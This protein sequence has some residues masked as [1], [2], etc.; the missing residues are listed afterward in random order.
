MGAKDD[1]RAKAERARQLLGLGGNG[2]Q[3]SGSGGPLLHQDAQL[4]PESQT[5]ESAADAAQR[6]ARLGKF[7]PFV[8]PVRFVPDQI[9]PEHVP[10]KHAPGSLKRGDSVWYR[11]G[12]YWVE[13]APPD[14]S[15]TCT[16]RISNERIHPDPDRHPP[17]ERESFC[18][19]ADLL[20]LAPAPKNAYAGCS[21]LAQEQRKERSKSGQHDVGDEVATLLRGK[22]IDECY[23]TAARFLKVPEDDLRQR[24]GHLN[25]GQQRMNLGNKMRFFL[26]KGS[27]SDVRTDN[28]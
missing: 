7:E 6:K 21:T 12:R 26:K 10:K 18:C 3:E 19:H 5:G 16:V 27:K 1:K 9:R 24:Y 17:K 14:W 28:H 23:T 25:P 4:P 22:E 13:S 8:Q 20:E 2:G 15:R 11:G